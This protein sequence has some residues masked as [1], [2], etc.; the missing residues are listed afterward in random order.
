MSA[1]AS[2]P[3]QRAG[4]I[5]CCVVLPHCRTFAPRSTSIACVAMQSVFTLLG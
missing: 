1:S 3:P 2:A 4:D 5:A